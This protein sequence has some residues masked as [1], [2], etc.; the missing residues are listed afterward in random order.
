MPTFRF[1]MLGNVH[2]GNEDHVIGFFDQ[3][4]HDVVEVR[5]HVDDNEVEHASHRPD[6]ADHLLRR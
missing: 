4:E 5:R 2:A 1:L 3:R 6:D